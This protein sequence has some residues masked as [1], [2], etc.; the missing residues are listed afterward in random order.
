[1]QQEDELVSVSLS[2]V[3]G[4]SLPPMN[5]NGA[6]VRQQ[7][8]EAHHNGNRRAMQRGEDEDLESASPST[9][10][11]WTVNAVDSPPYGNGVT[12][13]LPRTI[14]EDDDGMDSTLGEPLI[15]TTASNGSH[16]PPPPPPGD[17]SYVY[18]QEYLS[19]HPAM[20]TIPRNYWRRNFGDCCYLCFTPACSP[21]FLCAPSFLLGQVN[22]RMGLSWLGV[23]LNSTQPSTCRGNPMTIYIVLAMATWITTFLAMMAFD[24][25]FGFYV[26]VLPIWIVSILFYQ[27]VLRRTRTAVR[28]RY[29]IHD[30]HDVCDDYVMAFCCSHGTLMQ[31]YSHTADLAMYRSYWWTATGLH[32]PR[33]SVY[34]RRPA[35][36]P[37]GFAV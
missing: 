16:G 26:I 19:H 18:S 31:L 23:P 4:V 11:A 2:T 37:A 8:A 21:I 25:L 32:Q 20:Q 28:Q 5:R 10:E 24:D 29:Q 15:V 33:G 27:F 17:E 1:M 36:S 3:A 12:L 13:H 6:A 14:M 34:H 22:N 35:S 7:H 9:Q 30:N